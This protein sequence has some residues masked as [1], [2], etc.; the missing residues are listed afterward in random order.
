M[1]VAIDE[2]TSIACARVMRGMSSS[3]KAVAPR[4]ASAPMPSGARQGVEEADE[5]LVL[6]Q[7]LEVGVGRRLDASERT[8]RDVG[9]AEYVLAGRRDGGALL[10]VALIGE[11]GREARSGSR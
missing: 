1:I 8:C 2:S 6:A 3:A 4:R 7:E 11:A 9:L 5:D 10:D